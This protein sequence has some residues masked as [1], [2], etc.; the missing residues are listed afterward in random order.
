MSSPILFVVLC[1]AVSTFGYPMQIA[2]TED[3]EAMVLVPLS[4]VRRA[5]IYAGADLNE[6][7]QAIF[8]IKGTPIDN[9]NHRLDTNLFGTTNIKH[10]SP[11]TSGAEASYLHK[12]TDSNF[13]LK[14]VHT[15]NWGTDVTAAGRYNF[16]DGKNSNANIQGY[17][18]RH[19]GGM[20]GSMSPDYGV[21][22]NYNMDF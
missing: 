3:G 16:Y 15:E 17:Y 12:S 18:T 9:E 10:H 6:P 19:L 2:E 14:A 11:F 22:L 4:R 8:G 21:M 1:L 7:G 13:D 20:A 5:E